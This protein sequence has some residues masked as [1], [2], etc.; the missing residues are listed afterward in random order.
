MK[1]SILVSHWNHKFNILRF[2]NFFGGIFC[3]VGKLIFFSTPGVRG[4]SPNRGVSLGDGEIYSVFWTFWEYIFWMVKLFLIFL[5]SE[6]PRGP[7]PWGV[8]LTFR[9]IYSVFGEF[10][11]YICW[12]VKLIFIFWWSGSIGGGRWGPSQIRLVKNKIILTMN[13][14]VTVIFHQLIRFTLV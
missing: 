8:S 2:L 10:R 14:L 1:W 11:E 5:R 4:L 13:Y 12:V 7:P 6:V 3:H 9:E